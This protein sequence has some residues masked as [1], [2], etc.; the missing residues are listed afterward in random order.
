MGLRSWIWNKLEMPAVVDDHRRRD[1][2]WDYGRTND[3]EIWDADPQAEHVSEAAERLDRDPEVAFYLL[4]TLAQ[5]GSTWAM[6]TVGWALEVGR[7]TPVSLSDSEYW[8]RRAHRA[9][10][11]RATLEYARLLEQRGEV[12]LAQQTYAAGIAS[13][14]G[15]A[16]F[17]SALLGLRQARSVETRLQFKPALEQAAAL[18]SPAARVL[19]AKYMLRGWFGSRYVVQ[20]LPMAIKNLRE[21][22]RKSTRPSKSPLRTIRPCRKEPS[23]TKAISPKRAAP[24]PPRCRSPARPAR[25]AR[26]RLHR[27]PRRRT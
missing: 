14:W 20:G 11:T 10:C 16:L 6:V 4:L 18:G 24:P 19:L 17:R 3:R 1:N 2:A 9:G 26:C 12:G 15:P 21:S 5:K 27:S 23:L 8:Y 7:G 25:R 22:S 13:G